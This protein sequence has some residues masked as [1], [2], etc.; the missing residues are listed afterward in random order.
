MTTTSTYLETRYGDTKSPQIRHTARIPCHAL[1]PV[2]P[3]QQVSSM[4]SWT[5]ESVCRWKQ[6]LKRGP[7]QRGVTFPARSQSLLS[8]VEPTPER[9]ALALNRLPAKPILQGWYR[10]CKW[11]RHSLSPLECLKHCV[12]NRAST[13]TL[14]H[15]ETLLK[16]HSRSKCQAEMTWQIPK[17]NPVIPIILLIQ[18]WTFLLMQVESVSEWVATGHGILQ[19]LKNTKAWS[20]LQSFISLWKRTVLVN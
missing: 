6:K 9:T 5:Y 18:E 20:D 4:T 2:T 16:W 7:W 19:H 8:F 12:R 15:W 17:P 11:Q 1:P 13:L 3:Q 14:G 10:S